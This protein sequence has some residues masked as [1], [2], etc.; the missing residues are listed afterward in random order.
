V[1]VQFGVPE[2]INRAG[3]AEYAEAVGVVE[4]AQ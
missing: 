2:L 3:F 1:V 4:E